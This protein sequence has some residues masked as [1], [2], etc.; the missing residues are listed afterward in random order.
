MK[1]ELPR[2]VRR[3]SQMIESGLIMVSRRNRKRFHRA[4]R[5]LAPRF[6]QSDVMRRHLAR[7]EDVK[8]STLAERRRLTAEPG[9]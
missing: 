7:L 1:G 8:R 9:T 6:G 3:H 2:T 4:M 5:A